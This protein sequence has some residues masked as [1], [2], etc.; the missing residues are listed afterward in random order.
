VKI[1]QT[2]EAIKAAAALVDLAVAVLAKNPQ[3][4]V[5]AAKGVRAACKGLG[6]G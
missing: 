1:N 3:G 6:K 2:K 4:V 5:V